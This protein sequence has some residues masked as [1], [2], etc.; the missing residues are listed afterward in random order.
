MN[1]IEK[2]E[3]FIFILF[4]FDIGLKV[5]YIKICGGMKIEVDNILEK[6]KEFLNEEFWKNLDFGKLKEKE[7]N[8]GYRC[9]YLLYGI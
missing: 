7:L 6:I 1:N 2:W 9:F 8:Y 4:Y 5:L 3:M